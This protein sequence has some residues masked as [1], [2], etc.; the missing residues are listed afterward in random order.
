MTSNAF[1]NNFSS[2]EFN[3]V[4]LV[5]VCKVLDIL[6]ARD[7]R[8]PRVGYVPETSLRV[9]NT[10]GS[11]ERY[12]R[13]GYLSALFY[14]SWRVEPFIVRGKSRQRSLHSKVQQNAASDVGNQ[15]QQG[16]AATLLAAYTVSWN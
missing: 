2:Y 12:N 15:R 4:I 13:Q 10:R 14:D 3:N 7:I 16:R 9:G 5:Y 1:N 6:I 11:R 8:T